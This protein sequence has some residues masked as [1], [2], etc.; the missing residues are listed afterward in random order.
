LADDDVIMPRQQ[1]FLAGIDLPA[2]KKP[3]K[4]TQVVGP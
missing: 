2:G 1:F 4:V 3:A